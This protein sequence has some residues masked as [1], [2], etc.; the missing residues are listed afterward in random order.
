MN[1]RKAD[2][3]YAKH[4]MLIAERELLRKDLKKANKHLAKCN[5]L[6][7]DKN[8]EIK[9]VTDAIYAMKHGGNTPS[10]SDHAIVRYLER[11]KDMDINL[12]KLE[13]TTHKAAVY[14]DNLVVTVNNDIDEELAA[15]GARPDSDEE[16]NP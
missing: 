4:K 9:A 6:I 13:I 11:Y 10:V 3:L 8:L 2:K 16:S 7:K 5:K 12:I 1:Q 15:L 14:Q